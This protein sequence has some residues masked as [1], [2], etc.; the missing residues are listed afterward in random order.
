MRDSFGWTASVS[1]AVLCVVVGGCS[2]AGPPRAQHTVEEYQADEKLRVAQLEKCLRDPGTLRE[3]PD[4]VNVSAASMGT[5]DKRFR[6][7]FP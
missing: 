1:V 5:F 3:T 7:S 2:K 6:P 4:C